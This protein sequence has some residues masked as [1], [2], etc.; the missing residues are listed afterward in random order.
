MTPVSPRESSTR[1]MS[2]AIVFISGSR[3]PRVVTAGVPMR[4]PEATIGFCVSKGMVFL[5]TVM[6]AAS[7]D[8]A[9]EETLAILVRR[10]DFFRRRPKR[11]EEI[12][13]LGVFGADELLQVFFERASER[14]R[15]ASR[16]DGNVDRAFLD[17]RRHDEF[18]QIRHVHDIDRNLALSTIGGDARVH[19]L[20]VS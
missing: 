17:N 1:A 10:Q 3:R 14:R 13:D 19:A 6:F 4:T 5:L 11:A 8:D 18:A 15:F 7:S 20:I 2:W 12:V 9:V 16:R